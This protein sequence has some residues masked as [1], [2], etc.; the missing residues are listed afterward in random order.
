MSARGV[1]R[2]KPVKKKTT[3]TKKEEVPIR[4]KQEALDLGYGMATCSGHDMGEYRKNGKGLM[5]A[6]CSTCGAMTI[7][8]EE[9]PKNWVFFGTAQD[10]TCE[11]M[12]A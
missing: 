4:N 7:V 5:L 9:A 1:D 8:R 3:K 10:Y 2:R 6:K 12:Q 11:R